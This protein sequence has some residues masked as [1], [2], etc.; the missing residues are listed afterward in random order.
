M[1]PVLLVMALLFL[2]CAP[3]SERFFYVSLQQCRQKPWR[4]VGVYEVELPDYFTSERLPYRQGEYMGY[5]E[6]KLA[7]DPALFLSRCAVRELGGCL[8]PWECDGKPGRIF[9]I[10]IEEFYYDKDAGLIRIEAKEGKNFYRIAEP[11]E[12]DPMEAALRAYRRLLAQIG[13]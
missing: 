1:K 12:R 2:G 7:R 4:D 8:Y 3:K 9:H 6:R 11:V 5:L 13:R 10:R